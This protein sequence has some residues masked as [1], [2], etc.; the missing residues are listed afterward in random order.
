MD[1]P[2][3]TILVV[4][5]DPA[6]RRMWAYFLT[7]KGYGVLEAGDGS[8]ALELLQAQPVHFVISDIDMPRMNGKELLRELRRR[9]PFMPV[10]LITGKP[11][12][13]AAVE[14]IRVGALDYLSKPC[15]LQRLATIIATAFEKQQDE[16]EH[17][18][19][20]RQGQRRLIGEYEII[21]TLGEGAVGVVYLAQRDGQ[22]FAIKL[23]RDAILT[24][25]DE[26]KTWRARFEREATLASQLRHPNIVSVLDF[27]SS[28]SANVP[29]LVMPYI[30]GKDLEYLV[31]GNTP[32]DL[33]T[34][35]RILAQIADGLAAVHDAG[36][37]HRDIKPR[38]ILIDQQQRPML[39]DF[40]IARVSGLTL[41]NPGE[42]I[43]TPNYMAPEAFEDSRVDFRADIFA[44]GLIGYLMLL[45]KQAFAGDSLAVLAH[46]IRTAD[47]LKP[48]LMPPDF[49]A[50]LRDIL[51]GMLRKNPL[52]RTGSA[53][54]V[55]ADLRAFLVANN[56]PPVPVF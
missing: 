29:Y 26:A 46:R 31:K 48:E 28:G 53:T 39:T 2:T 24:H 14:S 6:V 15:N 47:P 44:L 32:P 17:T 8:Q 5:D 18:A 49:P 1:K 16:L 45:R 54:Q 13:E 35:V 12:L 9:H 19:V 43:G 56:L 34:A 41:T 36:I 40:G 30:T 25:G 7:S 21:R 23:L 55:A 22:Q 3:H 11:E 20:L 52:E 38:N 10:V 51:V 37:C 27:G 42:L 4:E 33:P 50:A